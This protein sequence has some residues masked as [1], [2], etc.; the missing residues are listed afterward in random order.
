MRTYTHDDIYSVPLGLSIVH[1]SYTRKCVGIIYQTKNHV[2]QNDASDTCDV[3]GPFDVD[4]CVDTTGVVFAVATTATK[5]QYK[6]EVLKKQSLIMFSKSVVASIALSLLPSLVF[7]QTQQALFFDIVSFRDIEPNFAS[8]FFRDDIRFFPAQFL[9]SS[10]AGGGPDSNPLVDSLEG[11][12]FLQNGEIFAPGT[13]P[14][15]FTLAFL[16]QFTEARANFYN[17]LC[18]AVKGT[19]VP[20]QVEQNICDYNFCFGENCIFAISGGD[21]SLDPTDQTD[22]AVPPV[23]VQIIGGTGIFE[24]AGGN[25]LIEQAVVPAANGFQESLLLASF[26]ITNVDSDL[27]TLFPV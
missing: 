15:G 3:L 14:F 4:Y 23:P 8:E 7:G 12:R 11:S 1:H 18:T 9:E 2:Y 27:S 21:F 10:V 17:S 22:E 5:V 26:N 25:G 6:I 19:L 24:L 20:I 16:P 13:N